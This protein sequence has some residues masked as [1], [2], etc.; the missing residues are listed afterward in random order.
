MANAGPN[1]NGSQFFITTVPCPHLD[2]KHVVFGE[3]V[4]GMEVVRMIENQ[5]VGKNDC[6]IRECLVIGCGEIKGSSNTTEKKKK[7]EEEE[8]EET[9]QHGHH[10]HHRHHRHHHHHHHH[11]KEDES[12]KED[13]SDK[14][15]SE[16][17]E[18]EKQAE[19]PKSV[20]YV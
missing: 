12:N 3:V 1:T 5:P 18:P 13:E 10:R 6:P 7:E 2:N 4:E 17:K 14:S 19:P 15:I 20:L 8:G 11:H 16:Q 9:K